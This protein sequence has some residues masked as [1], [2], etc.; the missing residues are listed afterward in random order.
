MKKVKRLMVSILMIAAVST[1]MSGSMHSLAV[2]DAP[3]VHNA[4]AIKGI[5][6]SYADG[7]IS[8]EW[9]K[10][11]GID[12]YY[13]Y[14]VADWQQYE[15][16]CVAAVENTGYIDSSVMETIEQYPDTKSF[17]YSVLYE[18]DGQME[19][20]AEKKMEIESEYYSRR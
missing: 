10:V 8:L 5:K 20:L 6:G 19:V 4:P 18:K 13:V 11:S 17:T 7:T 14:R 3:T 1:I 2:H 12:T 16:D 9:E 15:I